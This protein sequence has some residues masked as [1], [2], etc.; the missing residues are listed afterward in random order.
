MI[1]IISITGNWYFPLDSIKCEYYVESDH[2]STCGW[3]GHCNYYTIKVDE[4][5]NVNAAWTYRDPKVVNLMLYLIESLI[6]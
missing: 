5:E 2:T 3:K 6:A 4:K 1:M